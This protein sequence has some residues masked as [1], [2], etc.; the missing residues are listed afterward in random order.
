MHDHFLRVIGWNVPNKEITVAEDK[1]TGLWQ[2]SNV[3][4][5]TWNIFGLEI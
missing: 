1:G 2:M 4:N 3:S 5:F